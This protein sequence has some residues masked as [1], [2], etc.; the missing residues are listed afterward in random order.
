MGIIFIKSFQHK[1]QHEMDQIKTNVQNKWFDFGARAY[2]IS[3]D[4]DN[5]YSAVHHQLQNIPKYKNLG[6]KNIKEEAITGILNNPKIFGVKTGIQI[7][8]FSFKSSIH[9]NIL[10]IIFIFYFT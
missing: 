7:T 3:N 8:S 9:L 2:Y 5:F 10:V 1:K 6:I 4:N